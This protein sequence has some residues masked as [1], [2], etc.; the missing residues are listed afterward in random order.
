MRTSIVVAALTLSLGTLTACGS[1]ANG[2][3]C[4]D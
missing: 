3:Y 2:A 1:D 4:K